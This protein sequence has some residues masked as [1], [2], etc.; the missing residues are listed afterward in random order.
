MEKAFV[1]PPADY[2]VAA[3]SRLDTEV[4]PGVDHGKKGEVGIGSLAG[5]LRCGDGSSRDGCPV[6]QDNL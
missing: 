1:D 2:G 5:F 3:R 4:S 6:R